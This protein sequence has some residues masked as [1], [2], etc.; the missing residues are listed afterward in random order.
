MSSDPTVPIDV[1]KPQDI[2]AEADEYSGKAEK[3]Q[4]IALKWWLP[5]LASAVVVAHMAFL[6]S[7]ANK[8]LAG[9]IPM[10]ISGSIPLLVT[11][12]SGS[13]ASITAIIVVAFLGVFGRPRRLKDT[14]I[15]QFARMVRMVNTPGNGS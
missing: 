2:H 15:D 14:T 11:F 4:D 13:I 12:V 7:L 10:A 6:A 5:I 1:D 9:G 3:F 8:L